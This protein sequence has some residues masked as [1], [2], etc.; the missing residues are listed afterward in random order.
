MEEDGEAKEDEKEEVCN[1]QYASV[2]TD[3]WEFWKICH[4]SMSRKQ[5]GVLGKLIRSAD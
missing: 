2:I 5:T 4:I 1:M 3:Y